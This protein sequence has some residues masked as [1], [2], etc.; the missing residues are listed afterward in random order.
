MSVPNRFSR[1]LVALHWGMAALLLV[2]YLAMELRGFLPR[3]SAERSLAKALHVSAGLSLLLLLAVRVL[4][5]LRGPVPP[6]T[7]APA[8]WMRLSA[9]AG[10]LAL[11]GFLLVMPLLGWLLLSAEGATIRF[12]GLVVPPLVAPSSA[13][14]HALE[15]WHEAGASLGYLLIGVHVLAALLH[16]YLRRDDTLP[17]MAPWMRPR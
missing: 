4:V 8:P 2:V 1:S 17:R 14:A 15:A 10:H 3:G 5:R 9:A 7:P 6:I 11:Y 12:W 16:H 13:L